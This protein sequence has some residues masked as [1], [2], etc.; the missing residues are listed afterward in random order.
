MYEES[1]SQNENV[2]E[3]KR[4]ENEKNTK[5]SNYTN[6]GSYKR[7]KRAEQEKI[8]K[9][10]KN[11]E[12]Q[13]NKEKNEKALVTKEMSLSILGKN[14]FIGDSAA[15]SHMTTNKKGVYK[16]IPINRSVMIGN[17]QSISC[18]HKGKLDVICIHKDGSMAKETWDVKIVPQLKHDIFSFTKAMK[19]GWQM[20]GRWK[21]EG[22]INELFKTTR[23]SM[24]FD[25]MIPSGSSWFMGVKVQ[26]A[27]DQAHSA[28]QRGKKISLGKFLQITGH[29]GEHLL[30]PTAKYMKIELTG[31]FA[32]CE[33]CAQAKIWQVNVQK[34][35][36]KKVPTRSGYRVFIDI[37]SFKH[38]SRGGNRHWL[39]AVDEFSDCSHSFFMSKKSDQIKM[40][41]MWIKGLSRKYGIEIKRTR[42]DNSGENR[43]LQK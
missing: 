17:G 14:I 23:A 20:N 21:E 3:N 41:T 39:I 4:G 24:R 16:L 22:L 30:R 1:G 15:T 11:H 35:K 13:R 33:I 27:M 5:E 26:R 25:R 19:E 37:S 18:T 43:S 12:I 42:L 36:M 31:K 2:E 32:P 28:I 34:K 8:E 29:T 7:G 40:I 10:K 9:P 38:A 6:I